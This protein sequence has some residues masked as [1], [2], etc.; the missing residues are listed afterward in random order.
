MGKS[1]GMGMHVW[2]FRL[3]G[4]RLPRLWLFK[5]FV[6]GVLVLLLV[7][8]G[9]KREPDVLQVRIGGRS[10]SKLPFVIAYDQGLYEKYGLEVELLMSNPEFEEGRVPHAKFWRRVIRKLGF[11]AYPE[12]KIHVSGH[13]PNMY[14]QT[15]NAGR[16]K[17]VAIAATDCS[18][19]YYVV[20]RSGIET[21]EQVKGKRIGINSPGT[22]SAFAAFRLVE[23]MGWD[24]DFDVSIL[25]GG[26][27]VK[28]IEEGS[29]DVVIGGDEVF[30][31]AQQLGYSILLDTRDWDDELS[32][33]SAMVDAEW[34]AIPENRDQ[35]VRFL[36]AMLEGLALFHDD[37][38]LAVDVAH[39]WYGFPDRSMAEARYQRAD[40]VPRKPYP[41]F[42]GINNTMR[43]H[44]S[45]EMRQYKATDFYD[46]SLIRELD[47]SGFIDALYRE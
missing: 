12:T 4:R 1:L 47:E 23:R 6:A 30:E 42:E 17:R 34:L 22:T 21:L 35:A 39:R 40:Y 36:K 24:H 7:S 3:Q 10:M 13:T 29:V 9:S 46:D 27:T 33:N 37:P 45:H 16:A 28:D 31:E 11:E 19:R 15:R 44:D 18:V 20:A 8:C 5:G 43:I 2:K 32:G 41:C 14:G 26:R 38:E 25:E